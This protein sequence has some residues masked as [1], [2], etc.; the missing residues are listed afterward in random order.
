MVYGPPQAGTGSLIRERVEQRIADPHLGAA[1][2][3]VVS[4]LT[5]GGAIGDVAANATAFP[6]R[7][8]LLEVQFLG[9]VQDPNKARIRANDA[10]MRE[11]HAQVFP[12]LSVAGAGCYV[13]YADD[14][15]PDTLWPQL[16]W[17]DN[18][19][20]LQATKRRVD[21]LNVFH[22]LQTVRP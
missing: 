3:A 16:Y 19:A 6:H 9:Y 17:S 11:T 21:P 7:D 8:A 5:M 4:F 13:N 22:G 15:L 20:R 14:D 12:A 2:A 18:Y 1:D 10:W